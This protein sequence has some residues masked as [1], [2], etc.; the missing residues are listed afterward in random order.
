MVARRVCVARAACGMRGSH[1]PQ[2]PEG[3]AEHADG[4]GDAADLHEAHV[5]EEDRDGRHLRFEMEAAGE[6]VH[7]HRH[8]VQWAVGTPSIGLARRSRREAAR[9]GAVEGARLRASARWV[10]VVVTVRAV[11]EAGVLSAAS[12]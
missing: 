2:E 4:R 12:G 7:L 1:H 8:I 11:E 6:V 5:H 3:L 9:C 10:G